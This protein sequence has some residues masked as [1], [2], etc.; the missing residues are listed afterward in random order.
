MKRAFLM[1]VVVMS[2]SLVTMLAGCNTTE[3]SAEYYY[4]PVASNSAVDADG[5]VVVDDNGDQIYEYSDLPAY[6]EAWLTN[7]NDRIERT[8]KIKTTSILTSSD[9]TDLKLALNDST[10]ISVGKSAYDPDEKAI[11]PITATLEKIITN[12][13]TGGVS[14]ATGAGSEPI[15]AVVN[16]A[17]DNTSQ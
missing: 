16:N 2:I 14:S 12:V 11:A 17:T 13:L 15:E 10:E 5:V 4:V 3:Y 7:E 8:I 6:A 9:K 1:L